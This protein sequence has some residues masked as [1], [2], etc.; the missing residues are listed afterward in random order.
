[1]IKSVERLDG[2]NRCNR[3]VSESC[4]CRQLRV[5]TREQVPVESLR[6]PTKKNKDW[7]GQ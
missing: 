4:R 5:F 6:G 3:A 1:M 7:E 2:S